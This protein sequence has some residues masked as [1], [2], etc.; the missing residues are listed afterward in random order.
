M[1][2]TIL[3][4]LA[5]LP[6]VLLVI[7]AFAGKILAYYQ[8]IPVERLEFIDRA[9]TPYTEDTVFTVEQGGSKASRLVVYP[10]LA[11]N[12]KV[13]YTSQDES[14]C[15]VDS[16]GV[17]YGKHYGVTTVT[18]V[19]E[20]GEK[21]VVLNVE[22][23]A[24]IPYAV[25]LDSNELTLDLFTTAQLGHEVDAPVAVNKNVTF[26]SD[27]PNVVSVNAAGK[28]VARSTGTATITV[29]TV[30]GG[31][32]DTCV[33]TV[34]SNLPPI[35]F[36]ADGADNIEQNAENGNYIT[37]S[38]TLD[39]TPFLVL[40]DA[41]N[42]EDVKVAVSGGATV[43]GR[44]ITFDKANTIVTVYIYTG[45]DDARENLIEVKIIYTDI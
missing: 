27:N 7:I 25:M 8:H 41:I 9:G 10:T 43:D 22:V 18:A 35:Y 23:K 36:R 42:I 34:T 38:Q 31:L 32:T 44:T 37:S 17:I 3:L 29:T 33:V 15:T 24:S 6:I 13:N 19:S 26:T 2:K 1:K 40:D 30:S 5:I 21:K 20:D 45:S 11:T 14:I 16:D 39:L 28:L 12:Q 4:I